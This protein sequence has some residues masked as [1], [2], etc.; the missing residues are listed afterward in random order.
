MFYDFIAFEVT[1]CKYGHK[2]NQRR[3]LHVAGMGLNENTNMPQPCD[4]NE[5]NHP[6]VYV[7]VLIQ[8][9]CICIQMSER[10]CTW[11]VC[12]ETEQTLS[13]IYSK[14]KGIQVRQLK[15]FEY[16]YSCQSSQVFNHP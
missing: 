7:T 9:L 1:I 5:Q 13:H 12:S 4:P 3:L 14:S 2:D 15:Y 10:L 16:C 6:G 8:P 11:H